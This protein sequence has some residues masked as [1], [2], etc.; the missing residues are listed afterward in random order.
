M[1]ERSPPRSR[2]PRTRLDAELVG[3]DGAQAAVAAEGLGLP[4]VPVER[5]HQLVPATLAQRAALDEDLQLGDGLVV[6]TQ[7]EERRRPVLAHRLPQ[8]LEA[9][10]LGAGE[11]QV[12]ELLQTR[13]APLVQG[14][15]EE[16]QGAPVVAPLDRTPRPTD[17][18]LHRRDVGVAVEAVAR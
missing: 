14:D 2:A 10:R 17:R 12:G 16:R 8:L 3:Q 18:A 9:R 11:R 1:P 15:V 5:D 7:L 4:A 13:P 6:P